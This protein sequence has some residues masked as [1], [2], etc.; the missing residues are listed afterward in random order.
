MGYFEQAERYEMMSEV[1]KLIQP[2]YEK[3]RNSKVPFPFIHIS[4]FHSFIHIHPFLSHLPHPPQNMMEMFG[5]LHQAYRKV[6]E[7][8]GSGRR[9]LGT[10]FRVAF[11]GKVRREGGRE[12]GEERGRQMGVMGVVGRE[13]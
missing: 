5:K 6:V 9:Y 1:A 13:G 11:Y 2:F 10:Y 4:E 12:R 8:E 7:I 3:A